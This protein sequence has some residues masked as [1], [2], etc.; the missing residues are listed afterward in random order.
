MAELSKHWTEKSTDDF[1]YRIAADFTSQIE[2][3]L[4][5]ESKTSLAKKLG[6]TVGRISQVL[7]NPG[8]LR[9]KTMIEYAR[10]LGLKL[11]II[12]YNDG[13]PE[14]ANGPIDAEIFE[15]CWIRAGRP[16]DFYA[17]DA[18]NAPRSDQ[19]FY[20]LGSYRQKAATSTDF[21][22]LSQTLVKTADNSNLSPVSFNSQGGISWL[23]Q[24][25]LFLATRK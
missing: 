18:S 17:L 24:P 12:A 1:L 19:Q 13:D 4:G 15:Q 25:S 10:A 22:P 7:N 9:L 5:E 6:V 16:I 11:S 3:L 20:M 14:N 2:K 8:N 23:N 21:R